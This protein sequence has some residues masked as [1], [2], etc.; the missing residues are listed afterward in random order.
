M[1]TRLD[2][3]VN[4][5]RLR[6]SDLNR[7]VRTHSESLA[8]SN[9]SFE[10]PKDALDYISETMVAV[11]SEYTDFTFEE[12]RRVEAQIQQACD[13]NR[14]G[15]DFRHQGSVTTDTHIKFYSD[16]DLLVITDKFHD[17]KSPLEPTNP[18]KG[19]P[20]ADLLEIRSL[21]E[22]RLES[23]FPKAKIDKTGKKSVSIS[24]GSLSRKIDVIAASWLETADYRITRKEEDKGIKVLDLDGPK[25]IANFPFL[26]NREINSKDQQTSGSLKRLIRFAK[27]VR[28][29]A[30]QDIKFSSYDIAALCFN[31]PS[32]AFRRSNGSDF[33][34]AAE[35]LSFADKVR[36]DVQ[37]QQGLYVPNKT[38][39]IFCDDGAKIDQLKVIIEEIVGLLE[40]AQNS[41]SFRL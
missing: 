21:V 16:I 31:L 22:N 20:M 35:F 4:N 25:R 17:L 40:Q 14:V 34:L 2:Y 19:D 18:Y 12:C 30:E 26:H 24:G 15:V 27:S 36:L 28:Y 6:K 38:R 7:G 8:K 39:L 3:R 1:A 23:S 5:L 10:S 29:D 33:L 9:S 13:T 32:E 11:E 41:R 37:L